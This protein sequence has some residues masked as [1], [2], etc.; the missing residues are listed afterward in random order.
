MRPDEQPA[1]PSG[2][3]MLGSKFTIS[4]I[5]LMCKSFLNI[6]AD[7]EVHGL[8]RFLQLL[9]KR[10][11]VEG[12]ERGLITVSNHVS[13]LDDP[14]IWGVLPFSLFQNPDN[15]RWSLG[16]YDLCFQSKA[17]STFFTLG[18]VLPTHRIQHSPFGGL[19]QP[20][21]TQA[22][23]LLS[24]GPFLHSNDPPTP[25]NRSLASPDISDPFSSP[26]MTFSTNGTDT[27]PAPSAYLSRRH[28][29]VHIFPEGRVHQEKEKTMRYFKWGVSRL[30]LESEP[31]PDVVPMFIS[32]PQDIMNEERGFPKFLPRPGKKVS[33]TF[34]EKL[35]VDRVFG[36]LREKWR[37]LCA[38]EE[39]ASGEALAVGVLNDRLKYS[40]EAVN[41]RK[42]CTMRIRAAVLA[43]R[44][45]RG[46]SDE[47]PKVGFAETYA[48]EGSRSEGKKDDGSIV[49]NE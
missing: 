21:I 45:S 10:E 39:Q 7:T 42:E 5:G 48:I 13:V 41:L 6:F 22:I 43:V 3:W 38:Q 14:L 30:I 11:N 27:F 20:T 1:A 37:K 35:D 34:G 24:K 29:W 18:Q 15:M 44:R 4:T 49:R 9:H 36:D 32:G 33:I 16:S 17:L 19:F 8:D 2:Q 46:Y 47:D 31:C 12:R 25:P 23:R 28:A 40:E 26:H